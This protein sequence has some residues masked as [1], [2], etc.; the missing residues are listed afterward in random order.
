MV[1]RINGHNSWTKLLQRERIID[2]WL[3]LNCKRHIEDGKSTHSHR[4]S[5]N[6][7]EKEKGQLYDKRLVDAAHERSIENRYD[8][9]EYYLKSIGRI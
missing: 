2:W 4:F 8:V 1:S 9:F 3:E 7:I 5:I 6:Q